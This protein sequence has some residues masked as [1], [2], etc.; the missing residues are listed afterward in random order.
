MVRLLGLVW[1][2]VTGTTGQEGNW[3]GKALQI[4]LKILF[5]LKQDLQ[6]SR[7][8]FAF[9]RNEKEEKKKE[10]QN[11]GPGGTQK[12]SC[13]NLC[14]IIHFHPPLPYMGLDLEK[15]IGIAPDGTFGDLKTVL[16]QRSAYCVTV[17]KNFLQVS[18]FPLVY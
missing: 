16:A 4:L 7:L 9:Q 15:T 6:W 5:H 17:D 3:E 14:L 12:D 8:A 10:R 18:V 1:S 2:E 13:V 11:F